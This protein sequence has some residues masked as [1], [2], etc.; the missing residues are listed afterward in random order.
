MLKTI[1]TNS[2]VIKRNKTKRSKG[3]HNIYFKRIIIFSLPKARRIHNVKN[4]PI[5]I[6]LS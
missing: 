5:K 3:H 6:W 4:I 1:E 2:V